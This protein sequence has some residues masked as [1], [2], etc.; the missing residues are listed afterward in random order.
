MSRTF[1]ILLAVSLLGNAGLAW[2][3][4]HEHTA[5]AV[6]EKKAE[7]RI[8]NA[9]SIAEKQARQA[10]SQA[11]EQAIKDA[12]QQA[13]EALKAVAAAKSI[14]GAAQANADNLSHKLSEIQ[15]H[16]NPTACIGQRMPDDVRRVLT[17]TTGHP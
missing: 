8:A 14:A 6:A 12:K 4:I 10:Q 9:R 13:D 15:S 16:A 17:E 3:G 5:A 7:V 1:L 11:D 2:W